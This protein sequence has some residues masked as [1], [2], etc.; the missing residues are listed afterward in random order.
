MAD[1][2]LAVFMDLYLLVLGTNLWDTERLSVESVFMFGG[3]CACLCVL[4][5]DLAAPLPRTGSSELRWNAPFISGV[6]AESLAEIAT[7][8]R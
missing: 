8:E 6:P 1:V 3:R 5:F 2:A 7:G 4:A